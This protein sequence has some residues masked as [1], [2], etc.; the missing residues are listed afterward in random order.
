[1]IE[2]AGAIQ[3]AVIGMFIGHIFGPGLSAPI[4]C[5]AKA[6]FFRSP[7]C[8]KRHIPMSLGYLHQLSHLPPVVLVIASNDKPRLQIVLIVVRHHLNEVRSGLHRYAFPL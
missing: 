5:L 3:T 1:M 2:G 7:L 6:K 4:G 8:L